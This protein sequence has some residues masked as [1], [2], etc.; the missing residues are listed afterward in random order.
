MICTC[1]A[2]PPRVV[3]GSLQLLLT[4]ETTKALALDGIMFNGVQIK[5]KRP[6]NYQKA[7]ETRTFA[8]PYP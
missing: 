8:T 1:Y 2:W 6:S 7:V 3:T 4:Q 5:V